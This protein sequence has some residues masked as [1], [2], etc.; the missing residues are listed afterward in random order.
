MYPKSSASFQKFFCH[1]KNFECQL[2]NY[3]SDS[4]SRIK[5]SITS[6]QS[7]VY[8]HLCGFVSVSQT[9]SFRI[10]VLK[11]IKPFSYHHCLKASGEGSKQR[12]FKGYIP[13]VLY[14]FKHFVL[15]IESKNNTETTSTHLH[16]YL[17][18]QHQFLRDFLLFFLCIW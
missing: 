17:F 2:K 10:S 7:T 15:C 6:Q 14:S 3:F 18:S 13:S 4:P 11:L 1:L 9:S 8:E 5:M 16:V 12:K